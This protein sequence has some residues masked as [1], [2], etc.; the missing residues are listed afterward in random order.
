MPAYQTELDI[1]NKAL[2]LIRQNR[3]FNFTDHTAEA[4]ESAFLYPLA[5]DAELRAH[6]WRF[7]IRRAILYSIS[8]SAYLWTP[9]TWSSA[10]TYSFGQVVVDSN[11]NW[12][13]S[14]VSSNTTAL[15]NTDAGVFTTS[16]WQPYFGPDTLQPFVAPSASSLTAP[17]APTLTAITSGSLGAR[18][19]YVKTTYTGTAGESLVSGETSLALTAGQIF[20]VTSPAAATGATGY[21]VYASNSTGTELS[22][23]TTPTTIGSSYTEAVTGI[24]PYGARPP[25]AQTTS[26]FAGDLTFLPSTGVV[27]LSMTNSNTDTPPTIEWL[28]VNGTYAPLQILYPIGA[29]PPTDPN[30]QNVYRL[31]RG[32]L[33]RAPS[34]PRRTATPAYLGASVG[35]YHEDWVFEGNYFVSADFGPLML[36]YVADFVDV[37]GMDPTFCD[38]VACRM[39]QDLAAKLVPAEA[40]APAINAARASYHRSGRRAMAVNAVEVASMDPEFHDFVACRV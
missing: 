14:K 11:G 22:Q 26:Y 28:A 40:I 1:A 29:G 6:F 34:N 3:I 20:R 8:A 12:W 31:P 7:A 17:A 38:M 2:Q 4:Q 37:T 16:S 39:A 23:S 21:N 35:N 13:Q 5:R 9:P 10:T 15:P 32:Y 36:R 18:T 30:T 27:Y 24:T 25:V 33:V 19:V